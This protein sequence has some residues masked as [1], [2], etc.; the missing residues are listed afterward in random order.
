[1][2]NEFEGRDEKNL[3]KFLWANLLRAASRCY[4]FNLKGAL[5]FGLRTSRNDW[6]GDGGLA[7]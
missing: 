7:E 6:F 3:V 5:N 4:L 1:M 2:Q